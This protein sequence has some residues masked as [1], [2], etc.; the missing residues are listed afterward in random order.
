MCGMAAPG[1]AGGRL[2]VPLIDPWLTTALL[3][4]AWLVVVLAF[5]RGVDKGSR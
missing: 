5:W 4:A 3:G 1:R 2:R